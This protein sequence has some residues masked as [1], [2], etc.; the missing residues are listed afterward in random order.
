MKYRLDDFKMILKMVE[1]FQAHRFLGG[2]VKTKRF[3][4]G[5]TTKR[6]RSPG[7][8]VRLLSKHKAR[9]EKAHNLNAHP[10]KAHHLNARPETRVTPGG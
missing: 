2:G 10:K 5:Y 1:C 7:S 9:P 8:P 3:V 6:D 4:F